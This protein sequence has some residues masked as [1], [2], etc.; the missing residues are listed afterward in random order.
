MVANTGNNSVLEIGLQ[1]KPFITIP[2]WR[3]FDEQIAKAEQLS[4]HH[5]AVVLT[6]W[7]Q[8]SE[9]WQ[10]VLSQATDLNVSAWPTI[11]SA[12]GAQQAANYIKQKFDSLSQPSFTAIKPDHS[13]A[14]RYAKAS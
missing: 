12:N 3:F 10:T 1:A 4:R 13:G 2:E 9:A 8:T 7:P 6:E 14:S 11:L 5:L